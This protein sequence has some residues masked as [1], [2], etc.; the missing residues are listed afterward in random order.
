MVEEED[1]EGE[2]DKLEEEESSKDEFSQRPSKELMIE[3]APR[4]PLPTLYPQRL[5]KLQQETKSE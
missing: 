5:K 3:E 2:T 4:H 1:K